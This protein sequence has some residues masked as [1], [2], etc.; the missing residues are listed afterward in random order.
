[1]VLPDSWVEVTSRN[2]RKVTQMTLNRMIG[3]QVIN[4]SKTLINRVSPIA[5]QWARINLG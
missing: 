2:L 3:K 4:W 5:N 1:M